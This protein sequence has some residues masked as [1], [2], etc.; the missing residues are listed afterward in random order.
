ME[1][2]IKTKFN[3]GDAV[4]TL[5]ESSLRIIILHIESILVKQIQ[6]SSYRDFDKLTKKRIK[7]S[8]TTFAISYSD[9]E[10]P[11]INKHNGFS[12][13]DDSVPFYHEDVCFATKQELIDYLLSQQ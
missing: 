2:N 9:C 4:W 6:I 3:I 7:K 13:V 11:L 1:V 12:D 10:Y 8:V 5:E